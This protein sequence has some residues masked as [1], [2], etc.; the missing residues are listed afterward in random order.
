MKK[1]PEANFDIGRFEDSDGFYYLNNG[2][3]ICLNNQLR[4]MEDMG[5][6]EMEYEHDPIELDPSGKK[7][8]FATS[9]YLGDGLLGFF[10]VSSLDGKTQI[11]LPNSDVMGA[12]PQWLSNGALVYTGY[13]DDTTLFLMDANG[14]IR[15]I[16]HT[17]TFFVLP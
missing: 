2:Q 17:S 1:A 12:R 6:F 3:K 5:D 14:M 4:E 11:A 10:A 15:P 16:A 8:L 7:L 13:D 9:T